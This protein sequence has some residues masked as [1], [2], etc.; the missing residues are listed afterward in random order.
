M[1]RNIDLALHTFTLSHPSVV[2]EAVGFFRQTPLH[3]LPP[4][5]FNGTGVYALYYAGRFPLYTP[6]SDANRKATQYPIYVGKA[7]PTGWRLG[8]VRDSD[9]PK[10]YARL[11]EHARSIGRA[12]NLELD[13][14][15]C[16]FMVLKGDTGDLIV[17]VEAELIRQYGPLWNTAIDGFGN[18]DPGSGR[19]DQ[20]PSEWDTLHPG[21]A[22][23]EKLTGTPPDLRE[24]QE[25]VRSSLKRSGFS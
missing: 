16:R 5:S 22:W 13:A 15:W 4:V 14:F 7:V 19:Y 12:E 24:I 20:S 25:E 10:L 6:L 21:R 8:R 23:V 1:S 17:P 18:H 2:R 11:R 9:E 3:E